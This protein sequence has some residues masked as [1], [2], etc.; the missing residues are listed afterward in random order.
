LGAAVILERVMGKPERRQQILNVARDV[1]ARR[2]YH[3]AK[4]D[5]I[6]A[7]A[8]VARG[9][10]YLYFD[11]KRAIFE[12]IVDRTI[13]RLGMAI[14]RVDPHDRGRSVADQVTENIRRIVR[15]LLEDRATTKILL[16][17]A[18][19]VDP[20][21]DRKLLSFYDEMSNVLERSLN[22]GQALGVV[23]EG[24]VRLLSWLTMG[25][26]KEVCSQIVQRGAEYDEDK[27]VDGILA[28]FARG[29]LRV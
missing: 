13:A 11:D 16:S 28:L 29:Y 10:F 15:V 3:A 26:L 5:D 17:D 20:A 8:G 24:D 21:F 4:I 22:D 6:V 25:A 7:A 12:E 1:F 14:V 18:L 27:L 9:T 2:G 23:G 19:G